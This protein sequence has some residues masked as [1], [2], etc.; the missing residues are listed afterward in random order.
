MKL[1]YLF[2]WIK[3]LQFAMIST[4]QQCA[5]LAQVLAV[6]HA[7]LFTGSQFE[8]TQKFVVIGDEA[9]LFRL[10]TAVIL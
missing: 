10:S 1:S 4:P 2:V 3:C 8:S 5:H 7:Q 6:R 9:L